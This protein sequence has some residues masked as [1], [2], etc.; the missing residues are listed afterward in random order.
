MLDISTAL[1]LHEAEELD[2]NTTVMLPLSRGA[3][4]YS[5]LVF[6]VVLCSA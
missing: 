4:W 1:C 3:S 6:M 2:T 5:F